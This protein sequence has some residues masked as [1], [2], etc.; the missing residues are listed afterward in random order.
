[1]PTICKYK[2]YLKLNLSARKI[3]IRR[4]RLLPHTH[5]LNTRKAKCITLAVWSVLILLVSS[6]APALHPNF[7]GTSTLRSSRI[8]VL[9]A[10][11]GGI[12]VCSLFAQM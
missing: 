6:N 12:H 10:Y 3:E 11:I 7:L 1:M 2:R 5:F 9:E 4:V 8:L